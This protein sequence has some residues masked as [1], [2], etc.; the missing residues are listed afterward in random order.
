M[1]RKDLY[2]WYEQC[3]QCGYEGDLRSTVGL[4][5]RQ[6]GSEKEKARGVTT[7]N[8]GWYPVMNDKVYVLLDT[9]DGKDEQVVQA[10]Q[11]IP[12]VVIAEALEGPPD[13][14]LVMEASERQHLARLTVQAIAAVESMTEQVHL[15]PT[16]GKLNTATS[17]ELS[18]RNTTSGKRGSSKRI[19]RRS[20]NN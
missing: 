12:G 13:V 5:Q 17:P 7:L 16:R 9:V 19:S 2:G 14:I 4:G 18:R 15:L 3:L 20:K 1:V 11:E 8:R 10:L 6:A